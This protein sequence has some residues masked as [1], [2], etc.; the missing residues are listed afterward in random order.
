MD[1]F[2]VLV[3]NSNN[4]NFKLNLKKVFYYPMSFY[5]VILYCIYSVC[6]HLPHLSFLTTVKQRN[7]SEPKSD[8]KDKDNTVPNELVPINAQIDSES[9]QV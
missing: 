3:T 6:L 4:L 1:L 9:R 8:K 7:F 5:I 2:F